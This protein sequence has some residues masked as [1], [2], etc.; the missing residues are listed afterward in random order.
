MAI[1]LDIFA[2]FWL[3]SIGLGLGTPPPPGGGGQKG[4]SNYRLPE[5]LILEIPL[6]FGGSRGGTRENCQNPGKINKNGDFEGNLNR[7]LGWDPK[8]GVWGSKWQLFCH[9]GG[10]SCSCQPKI[11]L[12]LNRNPLLGFYSACLY[13]FRRNPRK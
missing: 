13:S 12:Y 8:I 9:F 1:F 11:G 5:V 7:N 4:G 10:K 6:G 3:N 2:C